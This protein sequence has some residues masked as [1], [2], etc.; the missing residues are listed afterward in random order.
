MPDDT[1]LGD[2]ERDAR[3][4]TITAAISAAQRA[5]FV[6]KPIFDAVE[7][8]V[9]ALNEAFNDFALARTA[10]ADAKAAQVA[11]SEAE[12][13]LAAAKVLA[14]TKAA[15][16][17]E[18][19]ETAISAAIMNT[20]AAENAAGQRIADL[21]KTVADLQAFADGLDASRQRELAET[22]AKVDAILASA[23]A[24]HARRMAALAAQEADA[25]ARLAAIT[26]QLAALKA[27]LG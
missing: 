26:D 21:N 3:M 13:A 16:A 14:D 12:A 18:A 11:K 10:S 27:K 25:S 22:Q 7:P 5:V 1:M 2:A 4:R 8:A 15:E 9:A 23:E 6:V 19:S 17:V 20:K 24:A